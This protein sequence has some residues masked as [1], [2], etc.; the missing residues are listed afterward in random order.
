MRGVCEGERKVVLQLP[1]RVAARRGVSGLHCAFTRQAYRGG[2]PSS[3]FRCR[4]RRHRRDCR[5][6]HR[7]SF[8]NN[9]DQKS[10]AAKVEV[11]KHKIEQDPTISHTTTKDGVISSLKR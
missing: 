7:V 2:H 3:R 5:R 6:R 10:E 8:G 11:K 1:S 4:R 9:L